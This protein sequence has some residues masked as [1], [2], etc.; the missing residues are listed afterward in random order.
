M[1]FHDRVSFARTPLSC[2]SSA[3][4]AAIVASYARRTATAPRT[5]WVCERIIYS[6][7]A[8]EEN[9][10]KH[11]PFSMRTRNVYTSANQLYTY[12]VVCVCAGININRRGK[13]FLFHIFL[14]RFVHDMCTYIYI[15]N[16]LFILGKRYIRCEFVCSAP[17]PPQRGGKE[18]AKTVLCRSGKKNIPFYTRS[19]Q[20]V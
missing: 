2:A 6:T 7:T 13:V 16:I 5:R 10:A 1:Y 11:L 15:Y 9:A 3:A 12:N 20:S 14:S 18:E 8:A 19:Y 17:P 4:A